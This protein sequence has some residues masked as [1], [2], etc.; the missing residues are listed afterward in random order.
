MGREGGGR[1]AELIKK[2]GWEMVSTTGVGELI[3]RG[4]GDSEERGE[5]Y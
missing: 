4:G 2:E 3:G 5:G 1:G